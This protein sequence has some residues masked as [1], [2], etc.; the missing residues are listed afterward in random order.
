LRPGLEPILHQVQ[1]RDMLTIENADKG[2][3]L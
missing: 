1:V 2:N 3:S